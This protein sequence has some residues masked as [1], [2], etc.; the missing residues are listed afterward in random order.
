MTL[1]PM[2]DTHTGP[3]EEPYLKVKD[4]KFTPLDHIG[5][6]SPYLQ[7][8]GLVK[9][10]LVLEDDKGDT[11]YMYSIHAKKNKLG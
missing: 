6:P 1:L 9:I 8:W 11:L 5:A 3:L 10:E 7:G 2:L 4:C